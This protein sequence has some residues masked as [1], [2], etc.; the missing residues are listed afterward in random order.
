[1]T[2]PHFDLRYDRDQGLLLD[3][4]P[5]NGLSLRSVPVRVAV[6]GSNIFQVWENQD[7]GE[8]PPVWAEPDLA[9]TLFAASA[10][11]PGFVHRVERFEAADG[12]LRFVAT[13][14]GE[15]AAGRIELRSNGDALAVSFALQNPQPPGGR[16]LPVCHAELRFENLT[17]G[18]GGM[19]ASAHPYGGRTHPVGGIASLTG[20]GVSFIHG[21]IGQGL[22]LMY[23]HDP[24]VQRG[25]QF[26]FMLDQR[27]VVWLRPGTSPDHA[28]W[29]IT[30]SLDRLLAPGQ[31]HRFDG[32]LVLSS[33]AGRPVEQMRRWRDEAA[34]R[35]RLL[36]PPPP[37]WAR[38]AN[39]IEWNMNPKSSGNGFTRLDDPEARAMLERWKSMGYNAIFA[40]SCNHVG[41]NWLSPFDYEPC[42]EVGGIDAE[43]TALRWAHELGF[44]IFLWVTTVGVDRDA[45]EVKR[46]P[47]WFTHRPGGQLFYAWD[48]YPKNNF[49]GYAPDADPLATGWRKWLKDQVS[50]VIARGYDGIFVDGCIPR[51]SNHA[52]WSWPGESRNAVESQ[53]AELAE[54]VRS[55]G[56]DLITF[57]EDEGL[58][59]QTTCEMTMGR[60]IQST[61]YFKKPSW[62]PGMGGGPQ[63]KGEPP[64]RIPPELA[65]DYLLIRYGSLLPGVVDNDVLEGYHTEADRPW[66]V[67]SLLCGVVPK[68]HSEYVDDIATIREVHGSDAPND[69]ERDPVRRKRGL[70][71]F[72]A[73]LRL[74]R[75]EPLVREAPLSIEGVTVEGDAAVVGVLRP[76]ERRALLALIQFANRPARAGV[77]LAETVDVPAIQRTLAGH[78]EQHRWS[79]RE[80]L[81]SMVDAGPAETGVLDGSAAWEIDLAPY[82]FRVFELT[83]SM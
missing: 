56:K 40:V 72:C 6:R 50:S 39:I 15:R 16:D 47:D 48:S 22:P 12:E 64:Q 77:K 73:L 7:S 20:A 55:L 54:H 19:F 69:A 60:Y 43:R 49:V 27:P 14:T 75:D 1:M 37:D 32:E 62:D 8:G 46:Y 71:E 2:P 38:R 4:A 33:Y 57:V 11:S 82:G 81:R 9:A 13:A 76:V 63:A 59:S 35:Y 18:P 21:T 44:R 79:V 23:L 65:R 25:V 61:P 53:V 67:Q 3:W 74:C 83:R 58:R 28:H 78:P 51:A 17:V 10:E 34:T 5:P 42:A 31:S 80:I 45:P 52:R 68:T 41:Q 70:D 26:E 36:P 66:Y 30:W 24:T 29:C